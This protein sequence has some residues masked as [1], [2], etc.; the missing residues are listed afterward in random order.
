MFPYVSHCAVCGYAVDPR[1]GPACQQ[2]GYPVFI[3]E[4][5]RYLKAVLRDLHRVGNFQGWQLTV[6]QLVRRSQ[7]RVEWLD[8]LTAAAMQP[9]PVKPAVKVEAPKPPAPKPVVEVHKESEQP[10]RLFSPGTFFADQTITIVAALG[11]CLLLLG[12]LSFV[13]TTPDLLQA[14]LVL[15]GVHLVFGCIGIISYRFRSFRLISI[16]YTAIFA[17]LLP[18][19]GYAGFRLVVNSSLTMST[20]VEIALAA[21]YGALTYGALAVYQ[22]YKLFGYLMVVALVITEVA[23]MRALQLTWCWYPCGLTLLAVCALLIA[24]HVGKES[25]FQPVEEPLRLY[26]YFCAI[27]CA[28]SLSFVFQLFT[29]SAIEVGRTFD[30]FSSPVLA[31][32]LFIWLWCY[33]RQRPFW[34]HFLPGL[35]LLSALLGAS[36]FRLDKAGFELMFMSCALLFVLLVFRGRLE[37]ELVKQLEILALLL[38]LLCPVLSRPVLLLELLCHTMRCRFG[39]SMESTPI[40]LALV[41]VG[42]VA[43][44]ALMFRRTGFQR[45]PREQAFVWLLVPG[46]LLLHWLVS[47]ALIR[48]AVNPIGFLLGLTLA[49]LLASVLVRKLVSAPYAQALELLTVLYAVGTFVIS[50]ISNRDM[51]LLQLLLFAGLVYVMA[52]YQRRQALLGFTL[53]FGLLALVYLPA[54]ALV[55][56]LLAGGLPL[57]AVVVRRLKQEDACGWLWPLWLLAVVY[58]VSLIWFPLPFPAAYALL[59]LA[60]IWYGAALMADEAWWLL[61]SIGFVTMGLIKAPPVIVWLPHAIVLCGLVPRLLLSR[62]RY[63]FPF[64]WAAVLCMWLLPLSSP[65]GFWALVGFALVCSVAGLIDSGM[66]W[67]ACLAAL[68]AAWNALAPGYIYYAPVLAFGLFG[69]GLLCGRFERLKQFSTPGFMTACIAGLLMYGLPWPP[70][71]HL[72]YASLIFGV[73]WLKRK[74][75]FMPVVLLFT[76]YSLYQTIPHARFAAFDLSAILWLTSIAVG[77]GLLGMLCGHV[78]RNEEEPG[79][80]R[81]QWNWALYVTMGLAIGLLFWSSYMTPVLHGPIMLALGLCGALTIGVVLFERIPVLLLLPFVLS[82]RLVSLLPWALWQQ[83]FA[84][85]LIAVLL[86]ASHRL[87]VRRPAVICPVSPKAFHLV[88]GLLVLCGVVGFCLVRGIW[89]YAPLT[90]TGACSLLLLALLLFW[91][92]RLLN[93]PLWQHGCIYG[94]G[95]LVALSFTW[96]LY[97]LGQSHPG[98]LTL[99]PALCFIIMTPVLMRDHTIPHYRRYAQGSAVLGSL[100]L[101]MPM[102]WLSIS[103]AN[104]QPTLMLAGEAL[105]LFL[106]GLIMRTRIFVLA[107]AALVVV[108]AIYTL[109]LPSTG[110][111]LSLALLLFGGLLVMLATALSLAR[112]RVARVW[113]RLK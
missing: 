111:P 30:R 47:V 68:L 90:H 109:F 54:Y 77:A 33:A 70:A 24:R 72:L 50:A 106:L 5:Q 39:L 87:W 27:L 16:I 75:T 34:R 103:E 110:L 86:F 82:L 19:A 20:D 73:L 18:L 32:V 61:M 74:P 108:S 71:V 44:L 57:L 36:A 62:K 105:A 67:L 10:K 104:L 2:C 64:Y 40:E 15:V 113:Q 101:L 96:E 63:A 41:V 93:R 28:V 102:L 12:S 59:A 107:G 8:H 49:S 58:G 11:A 21:L 31:M 55:A 85:N 97:A 17:L 43:L 66:F 48:L 60:V 98:L 83:V 25:R 53:L 69:L 23:T 79:L 42:L 99:A 45:V 35:F 84:C 13:I 80:K 92:G 9:K 22:R 7:V 6:E 52:L 4:E 14:F 51:M 65:V 78:R 95:I 56:F 1:K 26:S 91:C 29:L 89:P 81:Y 88:S 46:G 76:A 112:H 37:K 38:I 3:P 94:A 100:L